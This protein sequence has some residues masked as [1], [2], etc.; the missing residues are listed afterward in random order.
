MTPTLF[1]EYVMVT[2]LAL[3]SGYVLFRIVKLACDLFFGR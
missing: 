3:I 1:G 2:V